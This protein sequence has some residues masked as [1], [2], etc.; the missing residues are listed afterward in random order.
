MGT[1]FS[2]AV[3]PLPAAPDACVEVRVGVSSMFNAK[4]I[5]RHEDMF[6]EGRHALACCS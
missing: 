5:V 1:C 6:K 4:L 3:T 2:R